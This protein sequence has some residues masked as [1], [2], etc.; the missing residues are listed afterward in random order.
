MRSKLQPPVL[1]PETVP[2]P[3]LLD[4]LRS[5]RNTVLTLVCAP[6]GYGKTTLLSQ[7]AEADAGTT[8][9]A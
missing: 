6:A 4:E 3:H 5:G 1:P 8:R 9:F 7:W 2:R